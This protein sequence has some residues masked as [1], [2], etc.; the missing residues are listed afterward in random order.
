MHVDAG[1]HVEHAGGRFYDG[2]TPIVTARI[3]FIPNAVS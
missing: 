2:E 3:G 1:A